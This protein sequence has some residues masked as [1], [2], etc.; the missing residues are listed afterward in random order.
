MPR[1]SLKR[2][3]VPF[4]NTFPL[5]SAPASVVVTPQPADGKKAC[6]TA[7]GAA[8]GVALGGA[9][10]GVGLGLELGQEMR[11]TVNWSATN[12]SPH[13]VTAMPRGAWKAAL[14]AGPDTTSATSCMPAK[15][16]RLPSAP[17]TCM[18]WFEAEPNTI[19]PAAST[20]TPIT[21]GMAAPR[22]GPSGAAPGI[23]EPVP[24]IVVTSRLANVTRRRRAFP[25]SETTSA[26][27]AGL[28]A[29][30]CG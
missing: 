11:R 20:S 16:E 28:S 23:T 8:L 13:G 19:R 21:S 24:A 27:S 15:S 25:R 10:L 9:A 5:T 30:P 2:A 17:R 29:M 7:L 1:A 3:A 4:P 14:A 18:A 12:T 26:S 22:A 6:A